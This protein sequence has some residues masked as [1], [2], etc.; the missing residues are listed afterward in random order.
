MSIRRCTTNTFGKRA[1]N[2]HSGRTTTATVQHDGIHER[3]SD[4]SA[5][6]IARVREKLRLD[7][8]PKP[9]VIR[10]TKNVALP[11]LTRAK[12]YCIVEGCTLEI[13][14]RAKRCP[15]HAREAENQC[16]AKLKK[17]ARDRKREL[18]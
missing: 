17:A 12:N 7:S 3:R 13:D 6:A 15:V 1:S 11:R 2:E 9:I 5:A 14:C 8:G 10:P 16:R 4:E 18:A